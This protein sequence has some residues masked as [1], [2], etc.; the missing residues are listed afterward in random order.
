MIQIDI[1]NVLPDFIF[2][3]DVEGNDHIVSIKRVAAH[4]KAKRIGD[5]DWVTAQD[6]YETEVQRECGHELVIEEPRQ[7]QVTID[8]FLDEPKYEDQAISILNEILNG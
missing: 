5:L 4:M 3:T 1:F 8:T 2:A 6:G 7:V